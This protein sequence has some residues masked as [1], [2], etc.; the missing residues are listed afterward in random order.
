MEVDDTFAGSSGS[1]NVGAEQPLHTPWTFWFDHVT[2]GAS[3]ESSL[4]TLRTR[5][6]QDCG[7]SARLPCVLCSV[8]PLS[9]GPG[10][11]LDPTVAGRARHA[12][13]GPALLEVTLRLEPS[14]ALLGDAAA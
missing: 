7:A 5:P 10:S 2:P 9:P 4:V 1:S 12:P 14:T 6:T 11:E 13:I 3:Y 8:S